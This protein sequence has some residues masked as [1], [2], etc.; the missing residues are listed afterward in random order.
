MLHV[1]ANVA[2]AR[3]YL[4]L[5]PMAAPDSDRARLKRWLPAC[6]EVADMLLAAATYRYL[7]VGHHDSRL[8]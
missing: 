8:R 6:A 1:A 5:E 7:P 4:A 3:P 2:G